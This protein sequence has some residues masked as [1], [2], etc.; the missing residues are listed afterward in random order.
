MVAIVTG[1]GTGVENSSGWVLGSRGQL[2]NATF[3]R[4]GE[5]V[6]VNAANGNLSIDRTDEILIG[7]GPDSVISRNYNSLGN[8]T[9][10]NGD[11]WRLSSQRLVTGL[12]GT[13]N[14][15]GSTVTGVNWNGSSTVYTWDASR[16]AYVSASGS[17]AYDTLT[18]ASNA[19]T[20]TDGNSR[21]IETYDATNGGRITY[22]A[23]TDG[24]ALTYTYTGSLL[25]RVT[26]QDGE[27]T[28]L[29]WSGNNLTQIVTTLSAGA[30]VTS[31]KNT[32]LS[33]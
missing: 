1:T 12:T 29:T 13:V 25:T 31:D 5:S 21:A 7:E 23:D 19:W 15:T 17:G 33:R 30:T 20:W 8:S 2:G 14:T 16:S 18:Y 27:H 32:I 24:N 11:N 22:S 28:D 9:D 26:T 6:Y 3:G 4:Y 10:D